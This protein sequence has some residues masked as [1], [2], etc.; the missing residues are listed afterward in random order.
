MAAVIDPLIHTSP[1]PSLDQAFPDVV[2]IDAGGATVV[3]ADRLLEVSRYLRDQMG[4]TYLANMTAVDYPDHL[5]AV[6]HLYPMKVIGNE[7]SQGLIIK[8]HATDKDDPVIPSVTSVWPGANFQEREVYDMYGIRFAGHPY[9]R[10]VLMWDG[11]EG[12][13]LR[14]DYHEAYYEGD[15][16]PFASRWPGG[17][18]VRAEERARFAR[19]VAYPRHWDPAKATSPDES[20]PVVDVS[21]L[22]TIHTQKFVINMGPQH[23]STHGVFRMQ[24]TLDGETVVDVMPVIGYLHRNHE[25][26]GERNMW[27]Q[28]MP[29]TD[30]LD[31]FCSMGNNTGYAL[32]V[33]KLMGVEPPERAEYIRVIMQEFT[34]VQ[35]HLFGLGQFLSDLGAFFTPILYAIENREL[36]LDLFE[37]TSGSRMMCNYMRFGGVAYDLPPEFMPLA[38]ELA[39]ERLPREIDELEEYLTANEILH[40][41]TIGVGV[42]PAE[43][44]IGLSI[45]GPLLRAS[46]V[47][48]DI[49]RHQPYGIY[50]RFDFEIPTR[51]NGDLYD[52]YLIRVAEVRQSIR[53]LQ[54]AFNSLPD[55]PILAGR[56]AWQIRV[57]KGEA[58]GRVEN[59]KGETGFFVV[60]DGTANPYRYHVRAPSFVNIQALRE[61]SIGFKIADIVA[62]LGSIDIV[63]GELD[64]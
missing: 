38:H 62:N 21:E 56:K 24:V 11:F 60:S 19:N 34:R 52:R 13:P 25:K 61:M 40:S 55:G 27:L 50:D 42:L 48:Y 17:H 1:A 18:H 14:K 35:N 36:I 44:A 23:P 63:L 46:G 47:K 8:A 29:F 57:P 2:S 9:L 7:P 51:P 58:Y 3:Q 39:F 37:M 4:Y 49:R 43:A 45:S 53:I 12:W 64:R 33:E 16:K 41:R 20:L 6:Y 30:R 26:I 54:Q 10:R 5:E 15:T 22:N 31:Y 28:N 32:A 59:P